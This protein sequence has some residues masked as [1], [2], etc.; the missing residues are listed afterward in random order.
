MSIDKL[1]IGFIDYVLDPQRPG[2][3][4]LSDIV[5][6]M[7]EN[8]TDL[9]HQVHILGPYS[10]TLNPKV[11]VH[12]IPIPP[13]GLR[14]VV[15][16]IWLLRRAA[17]MVRTF[18]F[19]VVHVPEYMSSAVCV[20]SRCSVPIVLTVPGNI[21]HR[22]SVPNGSGYEWHYA[23][24]LKVAAK[25][26]A[27]KCRRVIAISQEMKMW[28]E[29]TGS[30]PERTPYIPLGVNHE[31][32]YFVDHSRQILKDKLL[33]GGDSVI[34]IYVGR[35]SKEKGLMD[36][37][38][39]LALIKE[40]AS[41]ARF[42]L[43][44]DGPLREQLQKKINDYGLTS[45]ITICA[46]IQQD[47]LRLWYSAADALILPSFTEGMSRTMGEALACGTPVIGTDVAGIS[48]HIRN[49][50]NGFKYK[51]G[52]IDGLARILQQVIQSPDSLRNLRKSALIYFRETLMWPTITR[53]IVEEVYLPI[54]NE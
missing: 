28:W 6:D 38:D 29:K 8:L 37:I 44:G 21:Y 43:I 46:W 35:L 15:G 47:T 34:F 19:D 30:L 9:G 10:E 54:L 48:D 26:S 53:R 20:L 49:G 36:L 45:I 2:R 18:N 11:S 3:S 24:V 22:L 39:A 5:W 13:M 50:A 27:K 14:N 42:Y 40:H 17:K 41:S 25:I 23:Q 16:N 52:D 33:D 7:A 51:V 31:R 12:R 4:G 32:F 1:K